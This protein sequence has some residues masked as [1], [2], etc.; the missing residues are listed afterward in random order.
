VTG[1]GIRLR[2]IAER[3][4]AREFRHALAAFLEAIGV[5]QR[6]IE[7]IV[8]AVG[9]ALANAVEH[10]YPPT[11]PGEVELAARQTDDRTL[12]VDVVDHGTFKKRERA[13]GR[14]FGLR[15]AEAIA[16]EL[17]ITTSSGTRV[18]MIFGTNP[19]D[20]HRLRR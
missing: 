13:P 20:A 12:V 6:L 4:A 7:D 18:Q 17:T 11:G 5:E 3:E 9:E 19:E 14:G 8:V 1:S 10:A 15:I 2:R 16:R